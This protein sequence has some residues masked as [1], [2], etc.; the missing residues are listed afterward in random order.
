M[1]NTDL[2]QII[3]ALKEYDGE[4]VRL[5][6]VCGTHTGHPGPDIS[7]ILG[8]SI[9]GIPFSEIAAVCV[10]HTS[11]SLTSSPSYSFNALIICLRSVFGI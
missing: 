6:E 5:M 7:F 1:P 9:D 11:I 10:P 3:D 2:K 4:E 8:E